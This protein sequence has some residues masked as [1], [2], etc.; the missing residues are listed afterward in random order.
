MRVA[1]IA[2]QAYYSLKGGLTNEFW[3][4]PN[5]RQDTILVRYAE[6]E[7]A[8]PA[9]LAH[10]YVTTPDGRQVPLNSV[11]D[12]QYRLAPTV[13]EHDGLRRAVNVMGYYRPGRPPVDGP[14]HGR[15]DAGD[16]EAEL[17]AGLRHWKC[18]AT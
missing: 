12:V 10:L 2:D 7:R 11:A 9:D 8:G 1:D 6:Q 4:L 5:L 3:Q 15:A 18:A 14:H 13:I 16:A 17:P